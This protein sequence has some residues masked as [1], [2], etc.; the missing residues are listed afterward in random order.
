MG[1]GGWPLAQADAP[2]RACKA[3]LACSARS[4]RRRSVPT[5]RWPIFRVGIGIAAGRAVAGRI[6]TA[7]QVKVTVFGPVVNLASRLEGMTKLLHAP[8]LLDEVTA[9]HVRKNIPADVMRVRRAAKVRPYGAEAA[10]IVSELL[11]PVADFPQLTDEQIRDYEQALE[12][13]IAGRWFDALEL[14]HLV[15]ARD[16]VKD[17]LTVFIAQKRTGRRR[18]IGTAS[19][20][21]SRSNFARRGHSFA[22]L[23]RD[24][25]S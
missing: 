17:F 23:C 4:R 21:C 15:P 14:L 5:I 24:H 13:F 19:S 1:F 16:R 7:D 9:E 20:R 12:Q 10:L 6:G 8:I 22:V 11:P 18:A 3:A 25:A 2:L